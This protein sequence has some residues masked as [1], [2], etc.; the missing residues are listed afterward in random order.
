MCVD[1]SHCVFWRADQVY[2]FTLYN[3]G[4]GGSPIRGI[5]YYI[6]PKYSTQRDQQYNTPWDRTPSVWER[7]E[8]IINAI[9]NT[10]YYWAFR[11]P[12]Y[13]TQMDQQYMD[14]LDLQEKDQQYNTPWDRAPSV[15]DRAKRII[16]A[17]FE[18]KSEGT[19]AILRELRDRLEADMD[20]I[21]V[22]EWA[23]EATADTLLEERDRIEADMD[24]IREKEDACEDTAATLREERDLVETDIA[25]VG[26][27][28]DAYKDLDEDTA[29]TLREERDHIEAEFKRIGELE[30]APDRSGTT[31]QLE[32]AYKNVAR[33]QRV[34]IRKLMALHLW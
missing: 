11:S 4:H 7:A 16:K 31:C 2:S 34:T 14:H 1:S 21:R 9:R 19:T 22:E 32:A 33:L 13:S 26:G 18:L 20:R 10:P 12:K 3:T 8:R 28:Q 24:R 17:V 27:I 25:R 6:M 30:G 23:C 5:P 29:D 15:W